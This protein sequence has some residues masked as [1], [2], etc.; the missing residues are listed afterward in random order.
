MDII[1]II[2]DSFHIE[3]IKNFYFEKEH[4]V[5]LDDFIKNE[6][7]EYKFK[8]NKFDIDKDIIVNDDII[9]SFE[10]IL[11]RNLHNKNNNKNDEKNKIDKYFIDTIIR[12]NQ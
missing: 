12:Q 9:K 4:V 5:L 10:V 6:I 11:N 2:K 8:K 1:S 3:L 7:M